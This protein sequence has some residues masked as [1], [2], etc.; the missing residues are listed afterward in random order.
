MYIQRF[1]PFLPA[2]GEVV[3]FDRSWYR[4]SLSERVLNLCTKDDVRRFL[5][6]IPSFER[7][8]VDS[9]IILIKYWLE[10]SPDEQTR[11]LGSRID[12][13][14]NSWKLT[15]TDLES[16]AK[17]DEYS[18]ARDKMF[19]ASDTPWA[20]WFLVQGD[21]KRRARLNVISHFAGRVRY[22][23][24]PRVELRL[25]KRSVGDSTPEVYAPPREVNE[26]F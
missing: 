13:P 20:P 23:V 25:P 2:A 8:M 1:V 21:N 14:R 5:N 24:P 16:Y 19:S 18:R 15:E 9:G 17:W 12:D 4:R 26:R 6:M 3:I 7:A 11:R 22:K 10:I